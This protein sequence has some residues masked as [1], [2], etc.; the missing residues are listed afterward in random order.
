MGA[1][2]GNSEGSIVKRPDGRWEARIT[3]PEGKRKSFYAKT[4]QEAARRLAEALRDRDRGLPVLSERQTVAQFL[5]AWLNIVKPS[6]GVSTWKTYEEII[7]LHLTPVL[8]SQSLAKLTP[9][10][11]QALYSA[12]LEA[13]L[14]PT[15]VH[16]IHATLHA[17]LELA[18]SLDLVVRSVA[19]RV[20]PPK[21]RRPEMAV[22]SPEQ[23]RVLLSA[24]GSDELEALYVV[25]LT[26][27]MRQGELL[28]L[29]WHDLDL[30]AGWLHIH[31]TVRRLRGEFVYAPPKTRRSRRAVALTSMAVE[32]LHRHRIHQADMRSHA[33]LAWQD[34]DLI[35]C[36]PLWGPLEGPYGLRHHF[37]PLLR[38]AGLP[39]IRFH[40]LRHTTATLLLAQGIHPKVVSEMLGHTTIGITMDIYS[41]VLPEM[42]REAA[43]TL[44]RLLQDAT[45]A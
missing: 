32:A 9:Q 39:R 33:G 45:G 37:R 18:V 30:E 35:F 11:V 4:R 21:M 15:T 7:R 24:I 20:T 41:H 14:S 3:L 28:A 36:D 1:K 19:D 27:G 38:R 34:H 25:A 23:S 16:H 40:D 10:H 26:T 43:H 6:V 8:G 12:K 42:Q 29:K 2:R 44:D 13:G 22:L 5:A 31:A 17:A